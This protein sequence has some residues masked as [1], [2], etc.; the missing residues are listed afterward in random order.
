MYEKKEVKGVIGNTIPGFRKKSANIGPNIQRKEEQSEFKER[1]GFKNAF[2]KSLPHSVMQLVKMRWDDEK[3]VWRFF[4]N[5]IV[6]NNHAHHPGR[7]GKRN[8]IYDSDT[9]DMDVDSE[10]GSEEDS[11]EDSEVSDEEEASG[12]GETDG[13]IEWTQD[14]FDERVNAWGARDS[15][16]GFFRLMLK[17]GR[18]V[19]APGTDSPSGRGRHRDDHTVPMLQLRHTVIN[20]V[21]GKTIP[22]AV[23]GLIVLLEEQKGIWATAT[24]NFAAAEALKSINAWRQWPESD[25]TIE[26]LG[27][28]CDQTLDI[29]NKHKYTAIKKGRDSTGPQDEKRLSDRVQQ[30]EFCAR[31]V[32]EEQWPGAMKVKRNVV[33]EI[34]CRVDYQQ[35]LKWQ[36]KRDY[37]GIKNYVLARCLSSY[38]RLIA[39]HNIT[40]KDLE[41][42]FKQNMRRVDGGNARLT[43]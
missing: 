2:S 27:Q 38:P 13:E 17:D 8:Q 36:G 42:V 3:K 15:D 6:P 33:Y 11:E 25:M 23:K 32:P 24:R 31:E 35:I 21:Y 26:G 10:E 40:N 29:L 1:Y 43:S 18:V 22:N 4:N 37:E 20:R 30:W 12:S 9:V 28:V 41:R 16:R 19:I 34:M 7:E 5:H 39:H 14:R